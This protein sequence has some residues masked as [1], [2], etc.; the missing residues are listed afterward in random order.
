M[1]KTDIRSK[2]SGEYRAG[3]TVCMHQSFILIHSSIPKNTESQQPK[4]PLKIHKVI[5]Q[6][7]YRSDNFRIHKL[8]L[9]IPLTTDSCSVHST[10]MSQEKGFLL[11]VRKISCW[12]PQTHHFTLWIA[13]IHVFKLRCIFKTAAC[14]EISSTYS[15]NYNYVWI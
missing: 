2:I 8:N 4:A 10:R 12:K 3:L 6:K 13:T 9:V 7:S 15:R 11:Y 14:M 5:S 1:T